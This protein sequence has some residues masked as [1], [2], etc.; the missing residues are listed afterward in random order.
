MRHTGWLLVLLPHRGWYKGAETKRNVKFPRIIK[1][2]VA[3]E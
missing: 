2:S 1:D 3:V